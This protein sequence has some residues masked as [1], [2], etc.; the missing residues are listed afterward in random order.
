MVHRDGQIGQKQE[1]VPLQLFFGPVYPTFTGVHTVVTSEMTELRV[2]S[3][4]EKTHKGACLF[5][6]SLTQRYSTN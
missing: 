1:S 4:N 3:S 2:E 6:C 5:F